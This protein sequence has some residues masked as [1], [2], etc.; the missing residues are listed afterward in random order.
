MIETF[1][2]YCPDCSKRP[3]IADRATTDTAEALERAGVAE[4]DRDTLATVLDYAVD[5]LEPAAR[6]RLFGFWDGLIAFEEG[7]P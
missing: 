6:E 4:A 5:Q 7:Q 3:R 2:R 1:K